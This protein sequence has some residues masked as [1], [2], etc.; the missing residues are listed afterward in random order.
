MGSFRCACSPPSVALEDELDELRPLAGNWAALAEGMV[1][2]QRDDY[3][4]AGPLH[5]DRRSEVHHTMR[6]QVGTR[7]ELRL[8]D[9][10]DSA[11][12]LRLAASA[13][14]PGER[15]GRQRR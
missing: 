15:H 14:R 1:S 11:V 3:L 4:R 5:L 2:I 6:D 7:L 9:P 10:V 8:G 12:D 13:H